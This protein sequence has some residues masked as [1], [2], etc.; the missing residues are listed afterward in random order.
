[1]AGRSFEQLRV[2]GLAEELADAVDVAKGGG[3]L[4]RDT[5]GKQMIRSADSVGANSAEGCG[6]GSFQDNRRF[7]RIARGSLYETRHWLR[8]CF[9]RR[10]LTAAQIKK[11][12]PLVENLG[13]QLNSYPTS[14]GRSSP[15][16]KKQLPGTND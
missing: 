15:R 14:I 1:M 6:R 9:R 10:L 5:I 8:R 11:L 4:A 7:V 16:P 2:Y 13:P 12:K 3:N